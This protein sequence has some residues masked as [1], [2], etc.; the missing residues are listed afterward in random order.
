MKQISLLVRINATPKKVY[1]LVASADGI[2]KWF[3]SAVLF[4]ND[5][6]GL[7]QLQLWGDTDFE[8]RE[9]SPSSRIVWHC[10]SQDNPWFGTDI[11]FEFRAE[12]GKTVVTF[13]H[14]GWSEINDF[15]RDCAMSWAY[16]LESLSSLSEGGE[17]TP[18]G[19][20]PPCKTI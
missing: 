14:I 1:T 10:I 8:V 4:T 2:A 9:L 12:S 15:Y 3:T 18:E 16:F 11:I 5:K 17:G 7:L 19:V 20:A 13:D 6:T